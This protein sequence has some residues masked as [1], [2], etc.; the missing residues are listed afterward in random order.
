MIH[1]TYL[2]VRRMAMLTL[3]LAFVAMAQAD[4]VTKK[5]DAIFADVAKAD[6]P[7]C[8]LGVIRDGKL[9]YGQG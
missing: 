5:V 6:S 1:S 4:D 8:A 9:I 2:Q 7:G 3:A